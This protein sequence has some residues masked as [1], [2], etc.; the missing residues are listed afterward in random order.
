MKLLGGANPTV[1]NSLFWGSVSLASLMALG[2]G[3]RVVIFCL[4]VS[5]YGLI[6]LN[7]E[8]S[9]GFDLMF[10]NGLWILAFSSCT[11]TWSLDSLI[12][13]KRWSS[14]AVIS[15]WPRYLLIF[16]LLL[17]YF[18]TGIQKVSP[19]WTP[20]GGYRALY[21]ALSDPSWYKID[22]NFWSHP[23][24]YFLTQVGTA[25]TWHWE[26]TAPLMFLILYFRLDKN[27][28]LYTSP[29]PRDATLSRM[30]SSA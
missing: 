25:V 4:S 18:A 26:Q 6:A 20:G 29:S 17:I 19:N 12:K 11:K 10:T 23:L 16:Q 22:P 13:N 14:D 1:I 8:I 28:L 2:L 5:Y 9:G 30:P 7:Y 15:A 21:W 3:G 24:T 27:C